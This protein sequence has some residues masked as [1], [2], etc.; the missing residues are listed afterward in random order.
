M[1][2]TTETARIFYRFRGTEAL[3][4]DYQELARR[5]IYFAAP[6][7]LNDPL[8]GYADVVWTGDPILWRNLLRHYILVLVWGIAEVAVSTDPFDPSFL[9]KFVDRTD[10]DFEQGPLREVYDTACATFFAAD[11]VSTWI[12]GLSDLEVSLSRSELSGYL[13]LLHPVALDAATRAFDEQDFTTPLSLSNFGII[14]GEVARRLDELLRTHDPAD[15]GRFDRHWD[16]ETKFIQMDMLR[17]LA[18][19]PGPSGE[20]WQLLS[21]GFPA[22]YI[23][24][25]ETL[26]YPEWRTAC[27]VTE[28]NHASMWGVYADGHK[29]VCLALKAHVLDN[30]T[31]TLRM[32]GRNGTTWD[33]INGEKPLYGDVELAFVPVH[34]NNDYPPTDFFLNLASL[35]QT[36]LD[37][38]WYADEQGT[39]SA[40]APEAADWDKARRDEYWALSAQVVSTKLRHWEHEGEHRL[41]SYGERVEIADRKLRYRLEDL[42]GIIFGIKTGDAEKLEII[43]T[44]AAAVAEDDGAVDSIRFSQAVFARHKGCIEI[45]SLDLVNQ[46]FPRLV[47]EMRRNIQARA[48]QTVS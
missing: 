18:D 32:S 19:L 47:A 6:E 31:P 34:Y 40:R 5:E 28:P 41:I 43:R 38:F 45:K 16:T 39:R 25:A 24:A 11:M 30:G 2:M 13:R 21:S 12:K 26:I 33:Q 23:R 29:G 14:F 10:V 35:S 9:K 15:A 27:F 8:E 22:A 42:D 17:L 1:V 20:G 48:S 46:S 44:L 7:E 4:G 3:L 37:G 36:A